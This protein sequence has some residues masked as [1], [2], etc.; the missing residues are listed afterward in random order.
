MLH[1][2]FEIIFSFF[3]KID[4]DEDETNDRQMRIL[5][6]NLIPAFF[7]FVFM[8]YVK[9]E[10]YHLRICLIVYGKECSNS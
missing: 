5:L 4:T 6:E 9:E 7:C 3:W 1:G 2:R 10:R 8:F